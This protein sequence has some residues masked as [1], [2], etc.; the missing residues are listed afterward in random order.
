MRAIAVLAC[1]FALACGAAAAAP[2]NA[3]LLVEPP[4]RFHVVRA[5][6]PSCEPKCLA[7]IAAQG[8]I[9]TGT[10]EQLR[11]VLRRLGNRKLPVFIDSGGGSVGE[12][13]ATGRLIRATGLQVAVTRTEFTPCVSADAACRKAESEGEL[14]GRAHAYL[15]KCASSCAFVLAG[16]AR[17]LVGRRTEVGVH[18]ITVTLLAQTLSTYASIG[19]YLREMGISDGLMSLI[20]STPTDKIHWLTAGELTRT[21]LATDFIDGEQL[22]AG[23]APAPPNAGPQTPDAPQMPPRAGTT[24]LLDSQLICAEFGICDRSA[25][26]AEP[27]HGMPG[28][29]VRADLPLSASPPAPTTPPL[30]LPDTA[31]SLDHLFDFSRPAGFTRSGENDEFGRSV[32]R[33][34]RKT[35]PD[36]KEHARVTVRFVLSPAGNL[37]ELRLVKSSG[38]PM[39]DQAVTYAVRE[40]SFPFPP[41]NAA[42]VDRTFVVTYIYE[43]QRDG[44][45]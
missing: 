5:A 25:A 13:L 15:S 11:K 17:R 31:L 23:I 18:Q 35:M 24:G 43:T 33:A 39:L 21:G 7:W 38:N 32:L 34:L 2:K 6:D 36:Q 27:T 9:V 28:S 20:T 22:V 14:R 29:R 1:A 3:N 42:P 16:G 40:S 8:K 10:A 41:A 4:M 26:Q 37:A 44:E 12:A 30:S 19:G 45:R